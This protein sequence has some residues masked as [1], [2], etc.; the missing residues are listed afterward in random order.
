MAIT[1]DLLLQPVWKHRLSGEALDS[2]LYENYLYVSTIG[3]TKLKWHT[4]LIAI[5]VNIPDFKWRL[6]DNNLL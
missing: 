5:S 6:Y 1:V 3:V 2:S 4:H